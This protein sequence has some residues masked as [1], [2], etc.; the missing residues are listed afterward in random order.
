[1]AATVNTDSSPQRPY[2]LLTVPRGEEVRA[3]EGV[4]IAFSWHQW[5][6]SK[7]ASLS[8]SP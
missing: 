8:D 4:Y 2:A 5:L 1:M 3:S 6:T 7:A